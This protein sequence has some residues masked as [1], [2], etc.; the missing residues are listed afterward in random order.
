MAQ[1]GRAGGGRTTRPNWSAV[2]PSGT[3]LL[4]RVLRYTL[5]ISCQRLASGAPA[6]AVCRRSAK[7]LG[8]DA[9]EAA[10]R[11]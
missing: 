4:I 3:M 11:P 7:G 2:K 8:N 9:H 10:T 1:R 6:R 5:S